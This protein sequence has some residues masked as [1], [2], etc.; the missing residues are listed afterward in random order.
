MVSDAIAAWA[1]KHSLSTQAWG[2]VKQGKSESIPS[3]DDDCTCREQF[4]GP[5]DIDPPEGKIRDKNCPVHGIDPDAARDRE[6][7]R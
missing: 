1:A 4:A 2:F 6:Q 7:D 5:T 3:E